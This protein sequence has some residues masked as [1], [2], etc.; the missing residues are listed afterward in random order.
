MAESELTEPRRARV[1]VNLR[2]LEPLIASYY[3]KA[4][5]FRLL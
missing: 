1:H 3:A 4:L 2:K 5:R